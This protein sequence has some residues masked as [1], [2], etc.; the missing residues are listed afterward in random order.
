MILVKRRRA[1]PRASAPQR[2]QLFFGSPGKKTRQAWGGLPR[3][4]AIV[5]TQR[6][7]YGQKLCRYS[8]LFLAMVSGS[9]SY[10]KTSTESHWSQ[11]TSSIAW[12]MG[13]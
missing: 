9:G 13:A 2:H 11:P 4:G 12:A 1:C 10:L 3:E 6:V 5:R 8:I 7:R